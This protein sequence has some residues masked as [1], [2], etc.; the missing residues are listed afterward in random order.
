MEYHRNMKEQ[1][2]SQGYRMV[3]KDNWLIGVSKELWEKRISLILN[4]VPPISLGVRFEQLK[5]LGNSL[6]NERTSLNLKPYNNML[7]L[8]INFR[9]NHDSSKPAK[10]RSK[11]QKDEREKQTVEF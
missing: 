9:F 11:I 7:L 10:R 8:K 1:V 3:D 6:Y 5:V 2:L 4:Y